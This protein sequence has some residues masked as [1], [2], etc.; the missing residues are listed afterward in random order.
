MKHAIIRNGT[1]ENVVLWDGETEWTPPE[2]TEL[3][4]LDGRPAGPGWSFDGTTF[5]PP[6]AEQ[7]EE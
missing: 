2:G 5:T 6:P 4:A 3:V 7:V 1:V